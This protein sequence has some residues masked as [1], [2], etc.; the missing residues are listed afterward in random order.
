[1][2]DFALSYGEK[3]TPEGF[4]NAKVIMGALREDDPGSKVG[5]WYKSEKAK[6]TEPATK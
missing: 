6:G 5:S 3:P 1:M 4:E 2:K